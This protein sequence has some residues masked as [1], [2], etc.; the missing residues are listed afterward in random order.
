MEQK[1]KPQVGRAVLFGVIALFAFYICYLV[2]A[3]AVSFVFVLL[4]KIPI[5][6]RI[7]AAIFRLRGD[8]PNVL[9]GFIAIVYSFSAV[10]WMLG[11]FCDIRATEKLSLIITG[12]LLVLLNLLFL[13]VNVS[14]GDSIILNIVFC[15][16][17]IV[18]ILRGRT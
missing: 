18:M 17:G 12:A 13:I 10:E 6:N 5:I 1:E 8:T 11:R 7:L 15:I 2:L 3:T 14:S 9:A 4:Y 16:A